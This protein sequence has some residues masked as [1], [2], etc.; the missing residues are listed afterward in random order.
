MEDLDNR[1]AETYCYRNSSHMNIERA[2]ESTR[3]WVEGRGGSWAI[4]SSLEEI[5]PKRLEEIH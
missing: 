1:G 4:V 3:T 2:R 5:P